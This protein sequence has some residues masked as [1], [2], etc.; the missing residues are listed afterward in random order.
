MKPARHVLACAALAGLF[1]AAS[2]APSYSIQWNDPVGDGSS[3]G[4]AVSVRLDFDAQGFW[5]ATWLAGAQG[6]T[7]NARFN[8]NLFDTA[9]G[10]LAGANAPQLSLDASHDFGAGSATEFVYS[11]QASYLGQ[12]HAGDEVS[13]GNTSNFISGIVDL[14]N[15]SSRDNMVTEAVIRSI[16]EPGSL[17]LAGLGLGLV[18]LL[19]ATGRR[20]RLR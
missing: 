3:V 8:L 4:D 16:P 13:T 7:G 12:W 20:R 5:T 18:G 14:N 17:A 1:Q 10:N 19:G 11:G 15:V 9:L 2:A 6:F